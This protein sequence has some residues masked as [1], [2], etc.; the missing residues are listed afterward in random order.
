MG[1][2]SAIYAGQLAVLAWTKLQLPINSDVVFGAMIGVAILADR[3][4]AVRR[5]DLST[6]RP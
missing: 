6:D 2:F 5:R 4:I 1:A 3:L